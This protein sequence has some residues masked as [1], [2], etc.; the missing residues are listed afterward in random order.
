MRRSTFLAAILAAAG[1][2]LRGQTSATFGMSAVAEIPAGSI[3]GSNKVFVLS[4]TPIANTQVIYHNGLAVF[5]GTGDY[6]MGSDGRTLTFIA[7]PVAG[8]KLVAVYW[9][10]L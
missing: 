3:N 4:N 6:T 2:A 10:R 9:V 7:A 1:R 8:D 5:M